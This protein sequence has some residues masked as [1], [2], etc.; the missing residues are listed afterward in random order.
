MI[1]YKVTNGNK[2]TEFLDQISADAYALSDGGTVSQVTEPDSQQVA[3]DAVDLEAKKLDDRILWGQEVIKKFRLYLI[4]LDSNQGVPLL[5]KLMPLVLM[6]QLGM[7]SDCY[8][9]LT[10]VIAADPVLD[11]PYDS[12]ALLDP[13]PAGTTVRQRFGNM[14]IA[15]GPTP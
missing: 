14:I 6:L 2:E 12:T 15:E 13:Q 4:N 11:G 7:L 3:Q 5:E 1:K 10:Y 9:M 8:G